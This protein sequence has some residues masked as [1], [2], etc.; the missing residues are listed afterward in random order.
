MKLAWIA[1]ASGLVMD[2]ACADA[3][4]L[5]QAAHAAAERFAADRGWQADVRCRAPGTVVE[6][7]VLQ[8]VDP[9]PGATLRSGPITWGVRVQLPNASAY[10][11]RVPLTIAWTA[12][13]WVS[14]R[15]LLPGSQLQPDD[16]ELQSRRWPDG[17]AIAAAREDARPSGRLRQAVPAG[18]LVTSAQL[19]PAG[20]LVRG[21]HVTAVLAEGAMEVRMP[22]QLLSPARVGE[23]VRA[24]VAGRPVALEGLLA[25]AQTLKVNGP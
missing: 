17:V 11:Q 13:A 1:F 22:A 19:L 25:D 4:R 12:P 14:Q 23:R 20:A 8:A 5:C 16:V 6:G 2:T 9:L 21:D 15:N 7:A 3:D 18:E 10:V 24:Q